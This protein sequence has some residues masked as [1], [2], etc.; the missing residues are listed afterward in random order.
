MLRRGVVKKSQSV[1]V[2][3][4]V[5][6][7]GLVA[8]G[9]GT[10]S[11]GAGS[12]MRDEAAS[13]KPRRYPLC[14]ASSTAARRASSVT[15][16][17]VVVSIVV[18]V[19]GYDAKLHRENADP[20]YKWENL[21]KKSRARISAPCHISGVNSRLLYKHLGSLVALTHDIYA[22]FRVCH[23]NALEVVIYCGSIF[24]NNYRVDAGS[25][26]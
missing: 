1:S 16:V 15:V 20:M 24:L 3:I 18:S 6:V 9:E 5:S 19:N 7:S 21:Q 23:L 14:S 11:N 26:L 10:A 13:F 2:A 25:A 22:V 12:S 8:P 17:G 4:S